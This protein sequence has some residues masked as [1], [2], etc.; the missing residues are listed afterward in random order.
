MNAIVYKDYSAQQLDQQYNNRAAVPDHQ[1]YFERW[2]HNSEQARRRLE[3]IENIAYGVGEREVLDVFPA[4]APNAPVVVFLHGGYWQALDKSY[5]SFIAPPLLHHGFTVVVVNYPLCP[6]ASLKDI[7]RSVRWAL[8]FLYRNLSRYNGDAERICLV[9]H[10][11]GGHLAAMLMA[12]PWNRLDSA[13]RNDLLPAAISISG[14][15]ELEPL[16]HTY[17]NQALNL[18]HAG[19]NLLSPIYLPPPRSGYVD[20]YVGGAESSEYLRQSKQLQQLWSGSQLQMR[21]QVLP[22]HNHFS[23]LDE[24]NGTEGKIVSAIRVLDE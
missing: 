16:R 12:T 4:P 18:D 22:G 6:A 8:I 13:L 14:L 9:G 23:I 15:F 17:V 3:A 10:S 7:V 19:C 5:F 24:L 11:A 21:Y 2:R 1:Q 20:L